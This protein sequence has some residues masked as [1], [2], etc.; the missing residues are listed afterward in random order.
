MFAGKNTNMITIQRHQQPIKGHA[1]PRIGLQH[2]GR[3]QTMKITTLAL[4]ATATVVAL[5]SSKENPHTA[6]VAR[7]SRRRRREVGDSKEVGNPT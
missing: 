5:D 7:T 1:D 3:G 6:R 4:I 2:T